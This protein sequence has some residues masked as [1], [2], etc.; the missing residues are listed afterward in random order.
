MVKVFK[1]VGKAGVYFYISTAI[2]K[3]RPKARVTLVYNNSIAPHS[4][5]IAIDSVLLTKHIMSREYSSLDE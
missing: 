2:V 1:A 5:K 4:M 3:S